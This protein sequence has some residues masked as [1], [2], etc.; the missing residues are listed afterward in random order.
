MNLSS[1]LVIHRW[2]IQEFKVVKVLSPIWGWKHRQTPTAEIGKILFLEKRRERLHIGECRGTG[3]WWSSGSGW[4]LGFIAFFCIA[5]V[6]DVSQVQT[7]VFWEGE[8][9]PW[10]LSPFGTSWSPSFRPS[11]PLSIVALT[12]V[13]DREDK[14]YSV[15]AS[16]GQG[17]WRGLQHHGWPREVSSRG[18]Q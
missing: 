5:W 16:W 1:I 14:V 15:T 4:G 18:T 13:R 7:E 3:N 9:S 2:H 8:V 17:W 6:R 10:S 11:F 12:A